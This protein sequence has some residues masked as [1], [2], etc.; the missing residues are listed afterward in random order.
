MLRTTEALFQRTLKT[1]RIQQVA[2]LI[3]GDAP[4]GYMTFGLCGSCGAVIVRD[5]PL[6]AGRGDELRTDCK[7][8]SAPQSH[9]LG[10]SFPLAPIGHDVSPVSGGPDQ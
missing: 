3:P 6:V 7:N 1:R 8:C 9:T 4:T 2:G 5:V 10:A